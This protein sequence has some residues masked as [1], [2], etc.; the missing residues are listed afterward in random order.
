MIEKLLSKKE[1]HELCLWVSKQ[2]AELIEMEQ[3][4]TLYL[5]ELESLI[6][7]KSLYVLLKH[8][9]YN[10]VTTMKTICKSLSISLSTARRYVYALKKVL[11]PYNITLET[12]SEIKLT[13]DELL[14]RTLLIPY[15]LLDN[16]SQNEDFPPRSVLLDQIKLFQ[17]SRVQAGYSL[18][19]SP[20]SS[21]SIDS[22]LFISEQGFRYMWEQLLGLREISSINITRNLPRS[23]QGSYAIKVKNELLVFLH[24]LHLLANCYTPT[25]LNQD[26]HI[27]LKQR[28]EYASFVLP[29][30][31]KH[32]LSSLALSCFLEPVYP[33]SISLELFLTKIS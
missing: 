30:S 3:T 25:A 15:L 6:H 26:F 20:V 23:I 29:F 8:L 10:P 14:I 24:Q 21:K 31:Q 12:A 2:P 1:Q 28:Y 33:T 4:L 22:H 19:A 18:L 13:G 11:I 7:D 16:L 27:L 32:P 5:N 17:N 9:A